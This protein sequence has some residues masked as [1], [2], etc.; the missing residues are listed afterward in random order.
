VKQHKFTPNQDGHCKKIGC[1]ARKYD[2]THTDSNDMTEEPVFILRGRDV[3]SS[4]LIQSWISLN[5]NISKE[6]LS[7]VQDTLERMRSWPKKLGAD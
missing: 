3:F 4:V 7:S 5:P 6:K 1:Y 2:P